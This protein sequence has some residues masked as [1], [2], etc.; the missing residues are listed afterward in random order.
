VEWATIKVTIVALLYVNVARNGGGGRR[1]AGQLV[2]LSGPCHNLAGRR[3]SVLLRGVQDV[4]LDLSKHKT[5]C[6]STN[7]TVQ[8]KPS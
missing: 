8:S 2:L 3:A 1:L 5:G 7:E 4:V 6:V